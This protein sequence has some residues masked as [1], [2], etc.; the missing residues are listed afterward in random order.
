MP[1]ADAPYR[2]DL[3]DGPAQWSCHWI[4]ADDGTKLRV[5]NWKHQA[6][7]GTVFVFHGRTEYIEKYGRIAKM[8]VEYGWNV[9][10]ID[11]RGQGYSDRPAHDPMQGYVDHFAQYQ[12]DFDAL[13]AYAQSV[14]LPKP[15]NMLG[16]SMGGCIGLRALHRRGDEFDHVTFSAPMWGIEFGPLMNP[17]ASAIAKIGMGLGFAKSY[18]PSTNGDCYLLTGE[19]DGNRLTNDPDNWHYMVKQVKEDQELRLGGPSFSWVSGAIVE[20]NDLM[21]KT[22]PNIPAMTLL[23]TEEA[24]V[25]PQNIYDHM[26]KWDNGILLNIQNGRHEVLMERRDLI[27]KLV[28]DIDAFFR[29]DVI[30]DDVL[31]A[32][33]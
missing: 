10:A 24:I 14:D 22:P 31:I 26:N 11:W 7:R 30:C 16:H 20:I 5:C 13:I 2:D 1:Y 6:P 17:F 19:F 32:A 28:R 27:E 4:Q 15:W 33:Q 9:V 3:A 29:D 21:S 25:K 12:Q 18:V 8:L 23:G